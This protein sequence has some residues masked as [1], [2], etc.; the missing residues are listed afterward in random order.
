MSESNK[1][2]L[3][4][5]L[6]ESFIKQR[7]LDALRLELMEAIGIDGATKQ[8]YYNWRRG[9]S[10]P[11]ADVAVKI[12]QVFKKYGVPKAKVWGKYRRKYVA[13]KE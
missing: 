11:R 3:G 12:E 10:I 1:Y 8:S 6:G 7:D 9:D 4:F 13:F 2:K 5:S